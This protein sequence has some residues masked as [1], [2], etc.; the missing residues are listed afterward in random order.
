VSV[1]QIFYM[2]CDNCGFK[3]IDSHGNTVYN[4]WWK[5]LVEEAARQGWTKK[6]DKN[7]CKNCGGKH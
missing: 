4:A 1:K 6:A 5:A 2:F 7:V 3:L